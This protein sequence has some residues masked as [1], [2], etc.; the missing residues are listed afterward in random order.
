MTNDDAL[1]PLALVGAASLFIQD[2]ISRSSQSTVSSL[3]QKPLT[4]IP[5]MTFLGIIGSLHISHWQ[6]CTTSVLLSCTIINGATNMISFL[7]CFFNMP[8]KG[9]TWTSGRKTGCEFKIFSQQIFRTLGTWGKLIYFSWCLS[10]YRSVKWPLV[11]FSH[12][13]CI[14]W[15]CLC[16]RQCF[17]H[18]VLSPE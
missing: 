13:V 11:S 12:S 16:A 5:G 10:A 17:R 7:L 14:Y 15:E 3:W 6:V 18:W 2:I 1:F 9:T 8:R 4:G